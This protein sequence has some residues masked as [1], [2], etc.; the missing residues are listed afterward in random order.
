VLVNGGEQMLYTPLVNYTDF[1]LD[2]CRE[3][4]LSDNTVMGLGDSSAH[5][6]TICNGQVTYKNGVAT[7][8]LPG[9]LIRGQQS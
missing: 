1:N 8:V 7:E 9:R 6:A 4:I 2:C 5:V 3:M